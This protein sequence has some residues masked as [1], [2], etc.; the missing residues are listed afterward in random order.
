MD[1]SNMSGNLS[2]P[3]VIGSLGAIVVLPIVLLTR[4]H[5]LPIIMYVVEYVAY[6]AIAHFLV[7]GVTRGFSWFKS[8]TTFEAL[9]DT[10]MDDRLGYTTPFSMDFWNR[11]L[12]NPQWI[13]WLEVGI[14]VALL[15]VVIFMRPLKFSG[16]NNRERRLAR[17]KAQEQK[18]K[19]Y[20]G[21]HQTARARR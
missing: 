4:K 15:Y 12:Y 21:R 16:R 11:E 13:F 2:D 8:Q 1:F 6:C 14:A 3:L 7:G 19:K 17:K 9:D 20:A 10:G 5:S 18:N